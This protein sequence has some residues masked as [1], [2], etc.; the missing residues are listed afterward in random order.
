M[1][2]KPAARVRPTLISQ[3]TL[4]AAGVLLFISLPACGGV[5]TAPSN[6]FSS[7]NFAMTLVASSTCTTLAAAGQNRGWKMGLVKTGSAVTGSMQGWTD[8]ATVFS[9]TNFTGSA[10]GS[11]LSLTGWIYDTVVGCGTSL[12]YQAEGTITATQS[13]YVINGTFNGVLTYEFTTCRA[14]D[15]KVTFTRQ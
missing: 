6:D 15:H 13:G 8:P 9:Q 4:R 7:G 1:I 14:S 10:T 3:T 5:T 12:C 11:S 2:R